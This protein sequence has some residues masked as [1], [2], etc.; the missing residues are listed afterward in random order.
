MANEALVIVD[1]NGGYHFQQT[2][3]GDQ[4]GEVLGYYRYPAQ[5]TARRLT[6]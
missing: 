1:E 3:G 5:G 2:I 6:T 4:T